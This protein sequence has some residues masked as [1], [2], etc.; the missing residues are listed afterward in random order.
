MNIKPEKFAAANKL[1]FDSFAA[2]LWTA[3]DCTERLVALNLNAARGLLEEN[4]ATVRAILAADTPEKLTGLQPGLSRPYVEKLLAYARGSY[5]IVAQSMDEAV[6]PFEAQFAEVNKFVS[7]ELEKAAK[8]VPVGS[9]AALAAVRSTIAAANST[10]DQV[11]KATRKV[12]ELAEANMT[13]VTEVAVKAA[14]GKAVGTKKS[15]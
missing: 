15:A 11:S 6:K 5:E 8:S 9:D 3:F 13:A 12:A 14:G 1:A 10:Y 4:T 7:I 2:A